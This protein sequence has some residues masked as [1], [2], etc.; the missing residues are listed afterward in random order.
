MYRRVTAGRSSSR[1]MERYSWRASPPGKSQRAVPTSGMNSVSPTKAASPTVGHVGR[2]VAGHVDGGGLQRANAEGLAVGEQAAEL[3]AV[4][5]EARLQVEDALEHALH[6]ADGAADGDDAAQ[7]LLQ[8]GAAERWSAWAWV[9]SSQSVRRPCWRTYSI[10][11][12]AP[13]VLVRPDLGS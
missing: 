4:Q 10:T 3:R 13:A 5:R 7:L 2:R 8:V 11:R 6:G 9:S 12:S 1:R